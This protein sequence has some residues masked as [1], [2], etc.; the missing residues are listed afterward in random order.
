[1]TDRYLSPTG[2]DSGSCPI[3]A[4]CVTVGYVNTNAVAGDDVYLADGTYVAPVS[5]GYFNLTK[6]L[7]WISLNALGA[8]WKADPAHTSYVWRVSSSAPAGTSTFTGILFDADGT[9]QQAAEIGDDT[10]VFN[11]TF[12]D[13]KFLDFKNRGLNIFARH[14]T[15]TLV[16][17]IF[18]SSSC[19]VTTAAG[20][21]NGSANAGDYAG[22]FALDVQEPYFDLTA[23][24]N[25]NLR[26]I[27]FSRD[28]S[29]TGTVTCSITAPHGQVTAH[30]SSLAAGIT[31]LGVDSAVVD[32]NGGKELTI[33]STNA[34]SESQGIIVQGRGV[35]CTANDAVLRGNGQLISFNAPAGHAIQLGSS[36]ADNYMVGGII[37]GW[38]VRIPYYASNTPHGITIGRGG[39]GMAVGNT[40]YGG[41]A[42]LLLSRTESGAIMQNNRVFDTY[43]AALY[44][45][46]TTAAKWLG[47]S[48]YITGRHIQRALAAIHVDSQGGVNTAGS[49]FDG[50]MVVLATDDA[51]KYTKLLGVRVNSSM[52]MTNCTFIIP[53]TISMSDDLFEIGCTTE[54]SLGGGTAYN[55]TEIE[56][57]TAGSISA[58]NG[59]GTISISGCKVIR[60]PI[61]VCRQIIVGAWPSVNGITA[62]SIHANNI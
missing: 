25:V 60:L 49:T 53:D 18:A 16:R 47:N 19:S 12:T 5:P 46:G 43:G 22:T 14:G 6:H 29:P 38:R 44:N 31:I 59:T 50:N 30:A 11:S 23:S 27:Y 4:P 42:S 28:T 15:H 13:C 8:T 58:T 24:A 41:Y 21:M 35:S 9:V 61:S 33:N 54:G 37:S 1:M 57:G 7:D 34:S 26:G 51:T 20:L 45:K 10:D 52:T 56:S 3:N 40:V 32:G 48:V 17:P 36:T 2:S 39:T 62:N 55:S